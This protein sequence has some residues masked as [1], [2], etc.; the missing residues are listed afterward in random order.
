MAAKTSMSLVPL[1]VQGLFCQ[2]R[3]ASPLVHAALLGTT[4]AHLNVFV[5]F[6]CCSARLGAAISRVIRLISQS[7]R[8]AFHCQ[9]Q[10]RG[11]LPERLTKLEVPRVT[12]WRIHASQACHG[13]QARI[14]CIHVV[15]RTVHERDIRGRLVLQKQ[16]GSERRHEV[17]IKASTIRAIGIV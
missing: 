11:S 7:G 3:Q 13:G 2:D 14:S 10:Q 5:D 15:D 6:T 12:L 16:I 4:G 9:A 1:F 17:V 8:A